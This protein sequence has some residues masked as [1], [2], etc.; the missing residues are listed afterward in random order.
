MPDDQA[1]AQSTQR[2]ASPYVFECTFCGKVFGSDVMGLA[3]HIGRTHDHTRTRRRQA[4][5]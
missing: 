4:S 1:R 5:G 3:L 2:A